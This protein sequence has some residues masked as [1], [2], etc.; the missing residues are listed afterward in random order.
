MGKSTTE[1][2]ATSQDRGIIQGIGF[3][4]FSAICDEYRIVETAT[5]NLLEIANNPETKTRFKIDIYKWV[6]EM[7]IGKPK[8]ITDIT[9]G[10]KPTQ[11]SFDILENKE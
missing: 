3:K 4:E 11:V 7:N 9:T 6:V 10:S 8:Q 1:Q 5:K 2:K